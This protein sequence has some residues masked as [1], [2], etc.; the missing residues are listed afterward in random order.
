MSILSANTRKALIICLILFRMFTLQNILLF[1]TALLS[2]LIM[3]LL[4]GYACSVNPGLSKLTDSE[5][6][7]AMKS[8]NRE[9]LNPFFFISFIGT[10]MVLPITTW[11]SKIHSSPGCFYLLLT[12][13][14]SYVTGVIGVTAFG[15]IPLNNLLAAFDI[16]N[17]TASELAQQRIL[18][19]SSWNSYHLIRTL[20]SVLTTASTI[21]ACIKNN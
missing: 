9:I 19:E 11:Y 15:N 5:Y 18:F 2:A 20:C 7:K 3:G 21:A 12:A 8:I 17:A 16:Q 6:L 4:Y 10:L 14:I 13:T 1:F